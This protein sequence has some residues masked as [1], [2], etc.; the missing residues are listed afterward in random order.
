MTKTFTWYIQNALKK[1][2]HSNMITPFDC[3][4]DV[5]LGLYYIMKIY[6]LSFVHCVHG[7]WEW[8]MIVKNKET[9]DKG[10]HASEI[11]ALPAN[12][13]EYKKLK[14]E[15]ESGNLPGDA[16]KYKPNKES[17]PFGFLSPGGD[18]FI[19]DWGTHFELAETIIDNKDFKKEYAE[20]ESAD[21]TN[22]SPSDF[23]C[24][25]KGYVLIHNPSN[26]GGY[27]VTHKKPLTKKQ[28]EFLYNYFADIGN[29]GRASMYLND[30]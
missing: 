15:F 7:G 9:D 30:D 29:Y 26:D 12:M 13:E 28:R 21:R 10:L 6:N 8:I 19:G 18:F 20:W 3:D 24:L 25:V 16:K 22:I 11:L 5:K 17:Q 1:L 2:E 27:V 4:Y 23:L 14:A